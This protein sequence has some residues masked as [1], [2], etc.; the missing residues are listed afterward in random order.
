MEK[1]VIKVINNINPSEGFNL[2][3]ILI[4]FLKHSTK[5]DYVEV[6]IN[7]DSIVYT[8]LIERGVVDEILNIQ[9]SVN[10]FDS[11]YEHGYDSNYLLRKLSIFSLYENFLSVQSKD[12]LI[13][14]GDIIII[15]NKEEILFN[16][17]KEFLEYNTLSKYYDILLYLF[18]SLDDNYCKGVDSFK[19]DYY[20]DFKEYEKSEILEYLNVF[21]MSISFKEFVFV[22]KEYIK[23]NG[24]NNINCKDE[25]LININMIDMYNSLFNLCGGNIIRSC[26]QSNGELLII[27]NTFDNNE[28]IKDI[29]IINLNKEFIYIDILEGLFKSIRREN[30]KNI[31]NFIIEYTN[32]CRNNNVRVKKID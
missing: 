24:V 19:S 9:Y 31:L 23:S 11:N 26:F 17:M 30:P 10:N 22:K 29:D 32:S 20:C 3:K 12:D 1:S 6:L 21:M 5:K 2:G 15:G 4:D 8:A 13:E 16:S 27:N 28:T 25:L 7:Y 14:R 18:K